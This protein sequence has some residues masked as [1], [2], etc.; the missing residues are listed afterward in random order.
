M[1]YNSWQEAFASI[2]SPD[3]RSFVKRELAEGQEARHQQRRLVY[4]IDGKRRWNLNCEDN[5]ARVWQVGRFQGDAEFWSKLLDEPDHIRPVKNGDSL[6]FRLSGTRDLA[7][8][9]AA[10]SGG[11]TQAQWVEK[12]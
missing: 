9:K 6:S 2:L 3:L 5:W 8:F 12:A 1:V 10:V 11:P 7:T 4:R